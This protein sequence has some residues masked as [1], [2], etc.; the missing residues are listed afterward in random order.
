MNQHI[1]KGLTVMHRPL[2][3]AL[4]ALFLSQ[5]ALA[6]DAAAGK[7]PGET[8]QDC[9]DCQTMVVVPAGSFIMGSSAAERQR[10]GV[11]ETFGSHEAPQVKI[12]FA[13]AF[14]FASTETT[15]AQWARFV[16]ATKR[17]IPTQCY[18]YNPEQDSWAGTPGKVVNWQDTGFKQ[19]DNH[20]AACISWQDASD[21]AAWLA[22]TTG[23]K[24]R[25][26]TEAEWEYAA[27]AGTTTTRPWGDSV[28][29][30]CNKAR[31]MTSG[32]FEAIKKG[33]SWVGELVC[34]EDESYTKP[35]ASYEA[36]PWG[37]YD[38]LGN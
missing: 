6:A 37:I 33:E 35:V 1:D 17:P 5:P 9:A 23:Q 29:P 7:K 4:L 27:R 38:T 11:P 19:T 22:K 24:Y 15:K 28:T 8:F 26:A 34:A 18:D 2:A 31:I 13:K 10:E 21:Y 25:L 30:I 20:P 3:I 16:A 12:T 36:N 14:A 32:T